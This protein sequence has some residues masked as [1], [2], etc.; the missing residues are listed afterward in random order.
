M[1][2]TQSS[3][4]TRREAEAEARKQAQALIAKD[5]RL[6]S[7]PSVL[8]RQI[9]ISKFGSATGGVIPQQSIDTIVQIEATRATKQ[10]IQ[11]TKS[12]GNIVKDDA[13][14][15]DYFDSH[16]AASSGNAVR[17]D[18]VAKVNKA[19]PS[20][21]P[22]KIVDYGDETKRLQ[23]RHPAAKPDSPPI[24]N[25]D[26]QNLDS[27]KKIQNVDY[28]DETE[29]LRRR[30]PA[31]KYQTG[32]PAKVTVG[33]TGESTG[34]QRASQS[35]DSYTDL[36]DNVYSTDIA[37][38]G[39]P[40]IPAEFLKRFKERPNPLSQLTSVTYSISMYML[41]LEEYKKMV[42]TGQKVLPPNPQL[43]VQTGGIDKSKSAR[44]KY[45]D[46]DFVIDNVEIT[47]NVGLATASRAH[48]SMA[49]KFSVYE[50][51]GI[52]FVQRLRKAVRDHNDE[53]SVSRSTSV[54][55]SQNLDSR[56]QNLDFQSSTRAQGTTPSPITADQNKRSEA[57]SD[58]LMVIRFFGYDQNGKITNAKNMAL[59]EQ[60][61]DPHAI[62]EKWIPFHLADVQYRIRDSGTEYVITAVIPQVSEGF[63]T[64][65]GSIPFSFE[66]QAQ[67]VSSLLN[68]KTQVKQTNSPIE[69]RRDSQRGS[70]PN[71]SKSATTK[72][73]VNG[74]AD[75]LNAHQ[76]YLTKS[77]LEPGQTNAKPQQQSIADQ[78]EILLDPIKGL[79]DA[80]ITRTGKVQ[81][82]GTTAVEPEVSA[83]SRLGKEAGGKYNKEQSAWRLP[84]GQPISQVIDLVMR[85][86]TYITSQQNMIYDES[87]GKGEGG[88]KPQPSA[89]IVMWYRIGCSLTPLGFDNLRSKYAYKYTYFVTPY[90]ISSPMTPGFPDA[91]SV[92]GVHKK[93]DYF[94]TGKNTEVI[95]LNLDVKYQYLSSYTDQVVPHQRAAGKDSSVAPP[96]LK[97]GFSSKP[98]QEGNER[99]TDLSSLLAHRLYS[100]S[101]IAQATFEILGDPDWIIQSEVFYNAPPPHAYYEPFMPDGSVNGGSGEILYSITINQVN[102]YDLNTGLATAQTQL[103]PTGYTG[104]P[105]IKIVGETTIFRAITCTSYFKQGKFT[106]RLVGAIKL[107]NNDPAKVE[108]K[109]KV[110]QKVKPAPKIVDYG[111]ETKRLQKRHTEELP[112]PPAGPAPGAAGSPGTAAAAGMLGAFSHWRPNSPGLAKI[113]DEQRNPPRWTLDRYLRLHKAPIDA[114]NKTVDVTNDPLFK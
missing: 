106:Q 59:G 91:D 5:P 25:L 73:Y 94:F 63:G 45:F 22:P 89:K 72:T 86:S 54:T 81:N 102:D 84:A 33:S 90:Q 93:Y 77:V 35:D 56:F 68:G 39:R 15:P 18:Q 67:D 40:T 43:L 31:A 100:F 49:I 16:F 112:P 64:M 104:N 75:A 34:D 79:G 38:P 44:N 105:D 27:N 107:D 29:R 103:E 88:Y 47:D 53:L 46:V 74:L 1:A 113:I 109:K 60:T 78:Y 57:N 55:R 17:D 97:A 71:A 37:A 95:N 21:P 58:F 36:A 85:N 99:L 50:P 51:T 101:D 76:K 65:S 13:Y 4:E 41:N 32:V 24:Q 87:L 6:A 82:K 48:N 9:D 26:F 62:I 70:P 14:V 8:A 69:E 111:D 92:R 2:N 42:V 110:E 96:A 108:Q 80:K 28:G 98:A 3:R 20:N 19:N 11:G 30:Y 66:L 23:K 83:K 114:K 61:S 52:T 10:A 12:A 7:M